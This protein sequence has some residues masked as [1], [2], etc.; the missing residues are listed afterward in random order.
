VINATVEK[1]RAKSP[2]WR[3]AATHGRC[4][5]PMSAGY[6]WKYAGTKKSVAHAFGVLP[7]LSRS[8]SRA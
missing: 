3:A 6:E 8:P 7:K 1:V 5:V 4:L 2:Y